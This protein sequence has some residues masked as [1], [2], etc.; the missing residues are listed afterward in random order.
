MSGPNVMRA[1]SP[2]ASNQTPTDNSEDPHY[3]HTE[4]EAIEYSKRFTAANGAD[5]E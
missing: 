1:H 5:P 4:Q 3:F 2:E